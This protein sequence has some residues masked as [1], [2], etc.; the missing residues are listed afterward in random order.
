MKFH[1][2]LVDDLV[3]RDEFERRVDAKV[4]ESGDLL[5]ERTAAMLVVRDLDRAHVRIRDLSGTSS[6]ACFFARVLSVEAPREFERSD[7]TTGIVANVM[8]GDE[9]GRAKLALWDEKAGGVSEIGVGS[10][11]EILGR[12]KG[13]GGRVVDVTAIAIQEAACD[14]TCNEA[15]TL[16]P[17][18]PAG[19]I[20]V[21]LI[22]VEAPRAFRRRDGSP[23]EMVEAVVGNEKGI[24]RLV[25]WVPETLLEAETGTNV[26]IRGA[27]ARESDRGIEYSLGEAGS[28]SPSDREIVIPMDTIAGIEEGKSYSIAGTVVS[29]QAS[30]SFVTK[31]GRPSS[32]RNLVI[33]DSTGEVPVV[34][35]GEKADGHLVSGDRIE[36]YNAA[37][38]RGRYGDTELHLSWGSALVVLAGEEEEVDV[39]GTV[40]ATGQGVALDTG[41]ACYLLAD[42]LPVGYDLRVR[43]SLH[44]GVITVH[45]AEAVIPD[46]G[47]LQ[48]RLDRFS[49][50]P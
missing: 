22:A 1:Y 39:R 27:V 13:G 14:I 15:D 40:I 44:R 38:R 2:L 25:A 12:P 45:H 26:V 37:A 24:F 9:T 46:P 32:V 28:V 8:V 42:P 47:D 16:A 20:E 48:S 19:D 34:I 36:V 50:Q 17:A 29:V 35:W 18:G 43:G 30:R 21:R 4:A 3:G 5:D 49:G 33:T 41:D 11:L 31:G 7:G 6:L 10:V 23:G